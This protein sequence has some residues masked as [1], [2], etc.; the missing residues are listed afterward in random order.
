MPTPDPDTAAAR[1]IADAGGELVGRTRLQKIAYLMQLAGFGNE[2]S[3]AYK[4]YGPFSE[5]LAWGMDLAAAFGP[6]KEDVRVADWG[7]KYSVFSFKDVPVPAST[8]PQRA[9][10]VQAAKEINAIELELAATA[11]FLA[12]VENTSD[13]W[14]ETGRRKP[15]KIGGGRL[16]QAKAAYDR[17]RA[18]PTP[19]PLP[20]LPRT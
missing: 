8:D 5:D 19:H 15:E 2:F 11:A 3:F 18:L 9:A 7:G 16:E 6:V 17:L 1:I 13:P 4:H 10:F 20:E 14:A 12:T